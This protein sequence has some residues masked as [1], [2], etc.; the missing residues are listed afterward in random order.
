MFN[1]KNTLAV[2]TDELTLSRQKIRVSH[3]TVTRAGKRGSGNHGTR[4]QGWKTREKRVWKAK[5]HLTKTFLSQIEIVV[6]CTK[7]M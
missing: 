2:I 6:Y 1:R 7:N 4:I 5:M 3:S